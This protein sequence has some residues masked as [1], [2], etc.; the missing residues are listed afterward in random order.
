[1]CLH[2]KKPPRRR[3]RRQPIRC[4]LVGI[5]NTF[6]A[7]APPTARPRGRLGGCHQKEAPAAT[8]ARGWGERWGGYLI[9]AARGS[10]R[11]LAR[12]PSAA[13][14][15]RPQQRISRGRSLAK[16]PS[17]LPGFIGTSPRGIL[18]FSV[19]PRAS[20]RCRFADVALRGQH[21]G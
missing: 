6:V 2:K 15:E 12:M 18:G 1:M 11:N 3:G 7:Y 13:L 5:G 20:D 9:R 21:L 16:P 19:S 14:A 17:E 10:A 8:G 4:L